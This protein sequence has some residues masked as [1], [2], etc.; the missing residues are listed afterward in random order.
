MYKSTEIQRPVNIL[1]EE[2]ES[3]SRIKFKVLGNR[4]NG[5]GLVVISALRLS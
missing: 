3:N 5:G 1:S 2:D 4:E